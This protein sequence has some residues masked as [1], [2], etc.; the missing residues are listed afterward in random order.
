MKVGH[1]LS[2]K[3]PK[4]EKNNNQKLNNQ[5]WKIYSPIS[6]FPL[7]SPHIANRVLEVVNCFHFSFGCWLLSHGHIIFIYWK[8]CDMEKEGKLNVR[9]HIEKERL[10]LN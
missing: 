9:Q 5:H 8:V 4:I 10:Q 3:F 7:L 1:L 2:Q 6:G